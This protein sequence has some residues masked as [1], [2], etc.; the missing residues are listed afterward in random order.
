MKFKFIKGERMKKLLLVGALLALTMSIAYAQMTLPR[1]TTQEKERFKEMLRNY[2]IPV[3]HGW[4][5]GYDCA[6]DEYITAKFFI[7]SVKI[8]PR[9]QIVSILRQARN[10]GLG[11]S[12]IR[13]RMRNAIEEN[14]TIISKG[15]ISINGTRYLLTNIQKTESSASADIRTIPNFT[16]CK[17]EGVSISD[18]ELRGEKV[19][20]ITINKRAQTELPGEPKVW[21][22]TLSFKG[23]DYKFVALAYP[24]V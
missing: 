2:F 18:C 9:D 4:G 15:R 12:Q 5:I 13:E 23:I 24:R 8:L 19:G 21:A 22:G 16:A 20:S 11:W 10:E 14:G 7:V 3:I 17:E 6:N 1:I